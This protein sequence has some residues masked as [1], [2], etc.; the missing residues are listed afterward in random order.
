MSTATPTADPA[1]S[2]ALAPSGSVRPLWILALLLLAVSLPLA[3]ASLNRR[4]LDLDAFRAQVFGDGAPPAGFAEQAGD[5]LSGGR[6]ALH[7]VRADADADADVGANGPAE[8]LFVGYPSS[9]AARDGFRRTSP[10]SDAPQPT[11]GG[12]ASGEPG[13]SVSARLERWEED[14]SFAW[15]AVLRS[16]EITWRTWRAD[17]LVERR[18]HQG[19][20][21]HEVARVNLTRKGRPLVLF[22]TWPD[23]EPV[24]DD[25]LHAILGTVSLDAR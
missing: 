11:V 1:D 6:R 15:S 22:A 24:D 4:H 2:K 13:E 25:A 3:V 21:W 14:P 23:E 16:G 10:S 8:L 17:L 20:G 9:D 18:F 12:G 19:G 7:Y 5:A